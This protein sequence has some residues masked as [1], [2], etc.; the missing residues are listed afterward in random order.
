MGQPHGYS[1]GILAK[2]ARIVSPVYPLYPLRG[3]SK[4]LQSWSF[5]LDRKIA[6]RIMHS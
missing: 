2:A 4:I 1:P 6:T 3:Y 5:D